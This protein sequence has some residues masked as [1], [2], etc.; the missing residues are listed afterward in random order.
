MKIITYVMAV[1]G[2]NEENIMLM[3]RGD[4]MLYS[5]DEMARAW[6]ENTEVIIEY[7]KKPPKYITKGTDKYLLY[8]IAL[9]MFK[10]DN[11]ATK[12]WYGSKS[13]K[14]ENYTPRGFW[15]EFGLHNFLKR[16]NKEFKVGNESKY[17]D[18]VFYEL[19]RFLSYVMFSSDI[20]KYDE[21]CSNTHR[22][23][24][25]YDEPCIYLRSPFFDELFFERCVEYLT[26]KSIT[27]EY[28][29]EDQHTNNAK[30]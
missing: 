28:K 22:T 23:G 29:G 17:G 16:I 27:I 10:G 1:F 6:F 19:G 25:R 13:P 26:V 5:D 3:N 9:G 20:D 15:K 4:I 30:R 11:K 14:Y 18:N 24:F 2:T 21:W 12:S 7:Y 8:L